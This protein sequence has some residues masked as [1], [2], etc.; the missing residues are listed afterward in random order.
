MWLPRD[1]KR[2]RSDEQEM[3]V[4]LPLAFVVGYPGGSSFFRK[5]FSFEFADGSRKLSC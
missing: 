1:R 5:M 3:D 4:E 2:A